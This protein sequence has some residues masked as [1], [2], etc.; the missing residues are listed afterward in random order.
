MITKSSAMMADN[1]TFLFNKAI[2]AL[3]S[4][5]PVDYADADIRTLD[6]Y[7]KYLP[8][9]VSIKNGQ[10]FTILPLDEPVLEID[11][12]TRIITIPKDLQNA[13]VAGDW[14]A[15]ILYFSIDRYFDAVDLG[16]AADPESG[17]RVCI[18]WRNNTNKEEGTSDAYLVDLTR[19]SKEGKVLIGWPLADAITSEAGVIEFAV[20]FFETE[21]DDNGSEAIIYSF[22]T[23]PAKLTISKTMNLDVVNLDPIN[24]N[25]QII[26]RIKGTRSPNIDIG[27]QASEP[28][29]I[30]DLDSDWNNHLLLTDK[31][32][33][34]GDLNL[35]G[36]L[37]VYAQ[38]YS[39]DAGGRINYYWQEK[40]IIGY[41]QVDN[42]NDT[43]ETSYMLSKDI[44]AQDNKLYYIQVEKDGVI[45]YQQ[46]L[47]PSDQ[48]FADKKI[49]EIISTLTIRSVGTYRAEALNRLG[50]STKSSYGKAI[51]VPKP[52]VPVIE[53]KDPYYSAIL[54]EQEDGSYKVDLVVTKKE[55][56]ETSIYEWDKDGI[57]IIDATEATY[58][59]TEPGMYTV[60]ARNDRNSYTNRSDTAIFRV[61]KPAVA[62]IILSGTPGSGT[63]YRTEIG[64][65]ISI[66]IQKTDLETDKLWAEWFVKHSGT[67]D[68]ISIAS[69]LITAAES[70]SNYIAS[71]VVEFGGGA[72]Y[73]VKVQNELNGDIS[74]QVSPDWTWVSI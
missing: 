15:E 8:E 40:G 2:E 7:F 10:Y 65:T 57:D 21:T 38:A 18:E 19:L 29:F 50:S 74:E 54:N 70:E 25:S 1:Y 26:N 64:G 71:H 45:G 4:N 59:A 42:I 27:P 53:T 24:V 63:G 23:L 13:G 20:R 36:Q 44:T 66:V 69:N 31:G 35:D 56:T 32:E 33:Y 62:P 46:E 60:N 11:A 51:T 68:Y 72:T 14:A 43:Y 16:A 6:E 67:D 39:P 48:Q 17:M 55:N 61:T 22:S 47:E 34:E 49:Y 41:D 30:I 5:N 12:N 9:L 58:T 28:I 3:K 52:T 37:K 73:I